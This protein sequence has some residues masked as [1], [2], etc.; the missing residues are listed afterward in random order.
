MSEIS[1]PN[2]PTEPPFALYNYEQFPEVR[3]TFH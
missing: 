2:E 1:E 3:V